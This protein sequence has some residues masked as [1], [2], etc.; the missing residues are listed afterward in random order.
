[1]LIDT[2]CHIHEF[3]YPLEKEKVIKRAH[4]AGV[5]QIICI[6][7]DDADSHLALELASEHHGLFASIGIHPHYA[8]KD[9][10]SFFDY[11]NS[12]LP[13]EKIVAIG[14]IG[15]DYHYENE[16][17]HKEQMKLLKHQ[18]DLALKYNLPVVLHIRE[19]YDDFWKVLDSYGEKADK[20]R[21]VLHSFTDSSENLKEG[22]KRGFYISING[23]STFTH[24]KD[25]KEMFASV[26]LDKLLLETDAPWLTPY[27]LRGKIKINEPAFVRE[28]AEHI[29]KVHR[30]SLDE[31]AKI[32]T[33][34]AR[35]LFKFK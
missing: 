17:S 6:G 1:M 5:K 33:A 31:I 20:I 15:L 28:V 26:P 21:G 30:V 18:I 7:S 14:E 35:A 16:P 2:H 13:N 22:L 19:A 8:D 27:P 3:D 34:N 24:D 9:Q 32:T 12:M 11:V 29:G 25:Q 4:K 10:S 23:I